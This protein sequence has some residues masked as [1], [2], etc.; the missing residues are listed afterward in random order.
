[1]TDFRKSECVQ[2]KLKVVFKKKRTT[3]TKYTLVFSA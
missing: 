1:M 3:I 2:M